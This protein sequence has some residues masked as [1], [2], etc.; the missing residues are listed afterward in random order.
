MVKAVEEFQKGHSRSVWMAEWSESDGLLHFHGKIYIPDGKDLRQRIVSQHHDTRVVGHTGR[1]KTLELVAQNYWWPQMSHYI[2]QYVK[3]C[4]LCLHTKAQQS[5]PI[6][7]LSLLPTPESCWDT[8]SVD[9]IVE[10]SESHGY[11]AIM[12]VIDSVSKVSNIIPTHTMIT[13]LR[14]ACLFLMHIW[15]LHGLP[16]QVVSDQGLQFIA[17]FTRELYCLLGIKLAA[18]MAYHPQGDGQMERVNQELEQYLRLFVNET[19]D[20]WDKLLPL[21]EFQYNN[22]IHST[23]QQTPFMLDSGRH[24]RMGFEPHQAES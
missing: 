2:G 20:D 17:Q 21:A 15:K 3:T 19:Q 10:L 7:E 1:W 12:N 23:T 8:I 9:F 5:L 4:D 13:A 16:K 14:V 24:P 6:R 22:H 18:T 11:D